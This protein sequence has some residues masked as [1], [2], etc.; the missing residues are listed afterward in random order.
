MGQTVAAGELCFVPKDLGPRK[1][2]SE[3]L[4]QQHVAGQLEGCGQSRDRSR[5]LAV[6]PLH[7]SGSAFWT[8]GKLQREKAAGCFV[9]FVSF[10]RDT[11]Y[12]NS[13]V[14]RLVLALTLEYT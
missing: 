6:S 9:C 10:L 12:S 14:A 4:E 11:F 1:R 8:L 3:L 2:V 5:F 13:R 7:L